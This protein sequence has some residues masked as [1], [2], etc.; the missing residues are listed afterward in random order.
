MPRIADAFIDNAVYIYSTLEDAEVGRGIGGSGFLVHVPFRATENMQQ[1]YVVTNRHV[2]YG[3]PTP[4]IHAVILSSAGR[5][6]LNAASI[7]VSSARIVESFVSTRGKK[8]NIKLSWS[9]AS[10]RAASSTDMAPSLLRRGIAI[11]LFSPILSPDGRV[12]HIYVI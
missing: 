9:R 6:A 3:T 1:I 4:V 10:F 8:L 12:L 2:V 7:P 5:V 11:Q